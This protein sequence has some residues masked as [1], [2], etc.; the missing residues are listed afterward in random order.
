MNKKL[1]CTLA[2]A[3]LLSG[4]AAAY[5]DEP[6][7]L[8]SAQMD[9]VTAGVDTGPCGGLFVCLSFSSDSDLG[10]RARAGAL[11]LGLFVYTDANATA[12]TGS[13]TSDATSV[14]L[15]P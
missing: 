15:S 9:R 11:A 4:M 5:A 10:A 6:M 7:R 8:S 1:L 3:A 14:S 12:S 2:G 13:A